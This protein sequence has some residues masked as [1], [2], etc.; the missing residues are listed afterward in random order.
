MFLSVNIFLLGGIVLVAA[1]IGFAFRSAQL[2]KYRNRIGELEKDILSNYS[3]I[4]DLQKDKADLEQR[5]KQ[6]SDIPVIPINTIP[7][8]DKKGEKLQDVSMRK[9][10]LSQQSD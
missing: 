7:T 8:E 1:L 6:N 10:L 2:S 9:K 5:L 4:L 3:D